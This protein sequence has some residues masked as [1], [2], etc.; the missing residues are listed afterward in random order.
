MTDN[1]FSSMDGAYL[2]II[3][4]NIHHRFYQLSVNSGF[5]VNEF[6]NSFL[7]WFVGWLVLRRVNTF[8]VI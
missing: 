4:K 1:G 2:P 7:G 8:W 5:S 6:D 3:K